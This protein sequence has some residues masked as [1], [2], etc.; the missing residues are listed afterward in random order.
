MISSRRMAR[1]WTLKILYQV[2][3]GKN[4]LSESMESA[5]ERL[6]KEFVQRGS[7]SSVGSSFE[8]TCLEFITSSLQDTLAGLRNE[9]ADVLAIASGKL[10]LDGPEWQQVRLERSLRSRLPGYKLDLTGK[11]TTTVSSG[12]KLDFSGLFVEESSR[13]Q[14]LFSEGSNALPALLKTAMLAD[15]AKSA[16]EIVA[17]MPIEGS[18]EEKSR[19]ISDRMSEF[20]F[21]STKRWTKIAQVVEKQVI[22]WLRVAAFAHRL[23][24]GIDSRQKDVDAALAVFAKGWGLERQVSVDRSILRIAAYE[25]LFMPSIPVSVSINEAVELAKKYSTAESGKFVN[26]MLGALAGRIEEIRQTVSTTEEP[27]ALP[28]ETP[29][30]EEII[31][32]EELE[33]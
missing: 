23:T 26:G 29:D 1:E 24:I 2:D 17:N 15:A 7:R 5:L 33:P 21:A 10:V 19:F 6:R 20:H 4:T 31:E 3:V 25:M 9:Y 8:D 18:Y 27:T 14:R 22:D 30:M 28:D 16:R 12:N 11:T 32:Q 13:I